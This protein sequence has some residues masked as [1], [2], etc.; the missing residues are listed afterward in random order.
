MQIRRMQRFPHERLEAYRLAR[1]L[2]RLTKRVI[3]SLPP[4]SGL[5]HNLEGE[6]VGTLPA[7]ARGTAELTR[8]DAIWSF[9]VARRAAF[10]TQRFLGWAREGGKGDQA[11]VIAGIEIAE[12]LR[13]Q[14][15]AD[16]AT[17][18]SGGK[19]WRRAE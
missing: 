6:I 2:V 14:L 8:G 9:R 4:R 18:R 7:I 16:I 12:R 11:A 19:P 15:T 5:A 13:A 10:N 3:D 1:K 17:L